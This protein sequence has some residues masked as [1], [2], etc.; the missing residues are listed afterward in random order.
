M[1]KKF[2]LYFLMLLMT[3]II[4]GCQE[5][6]DAEIIINK[7]GLFV[8]SCGSKMASSHTAARA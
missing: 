4:C 2:Y 1:M 8:Y 5:R 7:I 6:P 3:T